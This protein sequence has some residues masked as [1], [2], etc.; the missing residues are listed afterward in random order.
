MKPTSKP[1]GLGSFL[2]FALIWAASTAM[3]TIPL[4]IFIFFIWTWDIATSATIPTS[5]TIS[6]FFAL[7]Y[8]LT[9]NSQK[10]VQSERDQALIKLMNDQEIEPEIIFNEPETFLAVDTNSCKAIYCK[11]TIDTHAIL[12]PKDII[13]MSMEV[14]RHTISKMTSGAS[15]SLVGAATGGLLLGGAGAIVGAVAGKNSKLNQSGGISSI[16]IKLAVNKSGSKLIDLKFMELGTPVSTTDFL[17]RAKLEDANNWWASL[18]VFMAADKAHKLPVRP[19]RSA[20][21]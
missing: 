16:R 12:T 20:K 3:F 21:A 13:E 18:S 17:A 1:S 11:H 6:F 5:A 4:F 2:T 7:I 10:N 9:N 19:H 15:G 14:D 8:T